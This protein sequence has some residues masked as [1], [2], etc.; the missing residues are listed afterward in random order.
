MKAGSNTQQSFSEV[1][2]VR[3]VHF[4]GKKK[5]EKK[6]VVLLL[7]KS[8]STPILGAAEAEGLGP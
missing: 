3:Y 4:S 1:S 6:N 7:R 8:L 2:W 5:K